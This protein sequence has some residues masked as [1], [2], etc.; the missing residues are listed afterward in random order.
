MSFSAAAEELHLTHGAVSRQVKALED[1]LGVRLF[2]RLN[3]RVELTEAGTTLLP[4]VQ[5]AFQVLET[6]AAQ[7]AGRSRQGPLVVSCLA[8]FMIRW[9]I[10]KLY[11]FSSVHPQVEMR[12]SGAQVEVRLSGSFAPVDFTR[13]GIDVA[14]RVGNPPW[15]KGI[16]AHAFLED[17]IGPVCSPALLTRHGLRHPSDLQRHTLLHTESRPDAWRDWLDRS[18]VAD[19]EVAAGTRFEH[20]YFLLEA[21]IGGLGVGIGSYPLVEEDL[22]NGRLLAPFGFLP[23]GR[24]YYLLHPS[25]SA[26][27]PKVK[28]FQSWILDVSAKSAHGPSVLAGAGGPPV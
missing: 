18:D 13:D 4:A 22:K 7:V 9:L 27:V 25:Q 20:T 3:R 16:D 6:S 28:A 24:S 21:A 12:L 8:T 2:R 23:S 15:P 14:I 17:Y 5:T 10:P 19:V 26:V 1:Y 11:G